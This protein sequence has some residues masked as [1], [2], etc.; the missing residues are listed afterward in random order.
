MPSSPSRGPITTRIVTELAT[1]GFPVGDNGAP[2]DPY[3]WQGEPN[4]EGGS[5]IPWMSVTPG[6]AVPNVPPGAMGDTGAMWKLAYTVFYAGLSRK[7]T[8]ALADKERN[9]LTNIARESIDT[10][11]GN[12]KIMKITCTGIGSVNRVGSAYPD[13]HT[14]SDNFE[15]W[16]TKEG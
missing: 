14:Q 9:A 3:G 4:A 11:T 1:E 15:V 8:E 10:D 13:H 12:W 5:F 6:L 16:I 7:Q 2:A